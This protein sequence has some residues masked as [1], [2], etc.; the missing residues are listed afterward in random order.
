ML[1][2]PTAGEDLGVIVAA[3]RRRRASRAGRTRDQTST[4]PCRD[5]DFPVGTMPVD[6]GLR[7]RVATIDAP[8]ALDGALGKPSE[9]ARVVRS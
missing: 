5:P 4:P 1:R 9:E 7:K 8:H 3:K 2:P 6:G